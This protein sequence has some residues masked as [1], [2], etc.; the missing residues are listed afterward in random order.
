MSNE[1]KI[2]I[3]GVLLTEAQVITLRVAIST[4]RINLTGTNVLNVD[5]AKKFCLHSDAIIDLLLKGSD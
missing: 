4:F 2:A 1:T 3:N 5:A